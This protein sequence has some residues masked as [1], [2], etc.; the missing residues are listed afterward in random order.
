MEHYVLNRSPIEKTALPVAQL[1]QQAGL[2][3]R[4]S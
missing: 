3:E 2:G 1:L 4:Q